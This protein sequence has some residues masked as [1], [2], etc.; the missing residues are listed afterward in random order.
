M[1]RPKGSKNKA[2]G[3]AAPKQTAAPASAPSSGHNSALT[4]QEYHDLVV[5][6]APK[7]AV[8]LAN[9]KKYDKELKDIDQKIHAVL[10]EN[11]VLDIKDHIE[12]QT[13][14]GEKKFKEN[15]ARLQRMAA[16]NNL[17]VGTQ[18]DLLQSSVD[19]TP[20]VDRARQE[21][22]AAALE[23]KLCQPPYDAHEPQ[24]AWIE[25]WHDGTA[26][27]VRLGI[28][29]TEAATP[30][31]QPAAPGADSFDNDILNEGAG[32]GE[33]PPKQGAA[34]FRENVA[35]GDQHIKDTAAALAKENETTH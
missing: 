18:G 2:K 14:E 21:G 5:M 34:A 25:G 19:R 10:G 32:A 33:E 27:R 35:A 15:L 17:A 8:A 7:R 23:D 16:W 29:P 20:I 3:E 9:K 1:A 4:D 26:Q 12:L 13:P 28:K 11:G 30:P 24:Q 6:W 31:V 22:R